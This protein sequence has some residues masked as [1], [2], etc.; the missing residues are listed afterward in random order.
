MEKAKGA[1]NDSFS[2]SGAPRR[3]FGGQ[4]KQQTAEAQ[5]QLR[6]LDESLTVADCSDILTYIKL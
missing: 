3:P 6:N 4:E 1:F 5:S 2:R